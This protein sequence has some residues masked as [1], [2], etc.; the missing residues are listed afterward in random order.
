MWVGWSR[1]GN[2]MRSKTT[3]TATYIFLWILVLWMFLSFCC[4]QIIGTL[5]TKRKIFSSEGKN[6][7][8]MPTVSLFT[9]VSNLFTQLY[10]L[11]WHNSRLSEWLQLSSSL[12]EN[13]TP[14]KSKYF[15]IQLLWYCI[16][17]ERELTKSKHLIFSISWTKRRDRNEVFQSYRI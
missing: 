8:L 17:N 3:I 14:S 1:E 12:S 10:L 4:H 11:K 2:W 7:L 15:R 6:N 13:M 16:P 9:Q 5:T